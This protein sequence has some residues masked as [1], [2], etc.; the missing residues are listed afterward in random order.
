MSSDGVEIGTKRHSAAHVLAQA[1]TRKYSDIK[2]AIGPDIDNGFYYDVLL[3]QPITDADLSEIEKTMKSIVKENQKFESYKMPVDDAIA[4]LDKEG[5]KYKAEMARD[6]KEKGE[7]EISFYKNVNRKGDQTFVDMCS[8]PHVESTGKIGAFKLYT[9]SGAYWRGDATKDQLQ[10][11]YGYLFDTREELQ[12]YL[13][14]LEEAK[15]RDHRRIG[16]D[17][18]LFSIQESAGGGLVFWHPRGA[19][20]RRAIEEY[21][22]SMHA[23]SG[24][25][26]LYTP[27]IA[28]RELWN[29]SGH[30]GFYSE[31]M[32]DSMEDENLEFQ[33]KPMNCPFHILIYKDT[34]RSYRELPLR[35]AEMGTVYRREMSGALHGLMRVRGFTQDDAHIF[36]REDQIEEE[37]IRVLDFIMQ[38]LKVFGFEKFEVNL[39]TRPEKAVGSDEIWVMATAALRKALEKQKI[40]YDVDEGG[41]A[42]YGPKIDIKIQDAIGRKWQC[43]TVQL[44]FNLPARFDMEYVTQG[45]ERKRPI[46]IHRAL[47]GSV[48]RF[49]GVLIEHYMGAFPLWLAP[50]QIRI[51]PVSEKYQDFARELVEKFQDE[52][53]RVH[54][55]ESDETLSKKIRNAEKMKVPYML[56]VG[57]KE[58]SGEKLNVRNYFTGEQNEYTLDDLIL[59]LKKEIK[60]KKIQKITKQQAG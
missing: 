1:L 41:G 26:L 19:T 21:W 2:L 48:E 40:E 42:F 11:V 15:K 17:L 38:I 43:S 23:K 5:Q 12:E 22:Y 24:Y 27:H 16:E 60:E 31:S 25:D 51:L 8:G 3:D 32:F 54:V 33:L 47:L 46:M 37:V 53:I 59:S 18:H 30:T 9:V 7:N 57:E 13:K 58:A 35:W 44:D 52:D 20:I 6:L 36:C 14:F 4:L 45:N 10:R 34:L 29:T 56:V 39:S 28:N 55:D 50:E 49:F